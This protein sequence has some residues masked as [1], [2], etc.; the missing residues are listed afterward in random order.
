MS[1]TND[2]S[3]LEL[4]GGYNDTPYELFLSFL[5]VHKYLMTLS[6]IFLPVKLFNTI[7]NKVLF[8]SHTYFD[9]ISD[10]NQI[11]LFPKRSQYYLVEQ[12]DRKINKRLSHQLQALTRPISECVHRATS[13]RIGRQ[14]CAGNWSVQ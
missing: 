3:Y 4:R 11:G 2:W 10:G 7:L 8:I 6:L 5:F 12:F 1:Q 14:A 9:V 13:S